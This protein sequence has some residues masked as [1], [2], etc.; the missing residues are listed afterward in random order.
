MHKR[1][2]EDDGRRKGGVLIHCPG[3]QLLQDGDRQ[4]LQ[5]LQ[6]DPNRAPFSALVIRAADG[7]KQILGRKWHGASC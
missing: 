4:A 1:F 5:H 2:L 3:R 7:R 6:R